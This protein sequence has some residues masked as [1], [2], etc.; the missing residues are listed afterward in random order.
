MIQSITKSLKIARDTSQGNIQFKY[1]RTQIH[2]H[3]HT[4][5]HAH[6]CTKAVAYQLTNITNELS[7]FAA[8]SEGVLLCQ[9]PIS[10]IF[11]PLSL[12]FLLIHPSHTQSSIPPVFHLPLIICS[13]S[14]RHQTLMLHK[15]GNYSV[16]IIYYICDILY[17]KL[18]P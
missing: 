18:S 10:T 13:S 8:R 11:Y 6:K 16:C 1:T 14:Q 12:L 2:T 9:P 17:S 15:C 7:C 5:T 3:T 4:Q